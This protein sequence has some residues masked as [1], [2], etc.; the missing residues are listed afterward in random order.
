M[1]EFGGHVLKKLGDGLMALFG[2][3]AGAGERRRARRAR[4]RSPSIARSASSTPATRR[5][6]C[7]RWRRASASISGRWSSMPTGEVFGDAPNVAARVQ[8][9]AEPGTVAR[10]R[11]RAAPDR[12]PVRRR[13]QGRASTSRACRAGRRSTASCGRAAAAGGSG[14]RALT[15]L[16]GREEELAALLRRWERARRRRPVRADRR[17]ARPRQVAADRGVSRTAR[18]DAAHLGRVA[19]L[20]VAAEHAAASRRANGAGCASAARRS[21]PKSVSPNSKRRSRRSSSTPRNTRRCSRRCSTSDPLPAS[22]RQA[23]AGGIAPPPTRGD[24]RLGRSPARASQPI[25]LAFEDLHWADPTS[26]DLLE[27]LAERGGAGAAAHRRD[28]APGILARPGARAHHR[29]HLA[30]AAR[31][32]RRFAKMVGESPSVMRCR[33]T[34]SRA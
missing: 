11:R 24:R 6:A 1:T 26:L 19:S 4:R 7:R 3:P 17:R 25:V 21:P 30:R 14:A 29:R 9:A 18:R 15:P 27:A 33:A 32:R 13:G 34:P 23:R 16:V 10:H 20:A 8:T 31:S 22:R 5:A 2:Y 28:G 12:R